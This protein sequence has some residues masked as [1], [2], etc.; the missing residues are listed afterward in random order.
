MGKED[1]DINTI[2]KDIRSY[3]SVSIKDFF[4]LV[5]KYNETMVLMAF[6][7][8]FSTLSENEIIKMYLDVYLYITTDLKRFNEETFKFLCKKYGEN[9]I[10]SFLAELPD[11]IKS[12]NFF[13]SS[14]FDI[15]SEELFQEKDIDYIDCGSLTDSVK[16]YLKEIGKIPLL[17]DEESFDLLCKIKAGDTKAK[18]KFIEANLRLVVSIAKKYQVA[19]AGTSIG[20][21][22]LIQEGNMGLMKAIDKFEIEKKCRFSTYATWW[23]KQTILRFLA[24][25]KKIIRIPVHL[26]ET[27]NT[28]DK[29]TRT[30][31]SEL[32]REPTDDEIAQKTGFT[33]EKIN[34]ARMAIAVNDFVYLDSSVS[35]EKDDSISEV[36]YNPADL[37]TEQKVTQNEVNKEINKVIDT[38]TLRE[39]KVIRL[40]FGLQDGKSYTLEAIGKEIGVTRERVRQ[41]ENKALRKLRSPSKAKNIKDFYYN[42]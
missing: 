2:I 23:I 34:D 16:V 15:D 7:D 32:G 17:S 5:N 12:K 33:V 22:D 28:I 42:G 20:F 3:D 21:L 36:I 8:I 11:N 31:V 25:N 24:D 39:A 19:K 6:K 30:L 10:I 14:N 40:R 38:L 27:I 18:K 37:T 4:D 26:T 1:F 29:A 41:I 13:I 35:D 9:N